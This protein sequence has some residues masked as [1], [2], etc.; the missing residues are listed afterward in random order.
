MST[1]S[2]EQ[3]E[4]G[5]GGVGVD[6]RT[7]PSA[8]GWR[9]TF[10]RGLVALC[11][12]GALLVAGAGQSRLA[13]FIGMYWLLGAVLTIRWV[14][15]SPGVPGR[16]LGTLAAGVGALT[17]VA[18]LARS[19]LENV[20]ST[21][22]VLD[23]VGAGAIATGVMRT[24]GGFR[25]DQLADERLRRRTSMLVGALD[26]GLGIVLIVTSDST[27]TWVRFLA[28]AWGLAGGTLLLVEALRLR[29]FARTSAEANSAS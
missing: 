13:T 1:P 2:G 18:L 15:R 26:V 14:L 4:L 28:A 10:V 8:R 16:R 19:P 17:A 27:S 7:N 6:E 21:G 24:L 5:L 29:R 20:I 3:V 12:G 23:L 11:L 25:D 22:V 9:L